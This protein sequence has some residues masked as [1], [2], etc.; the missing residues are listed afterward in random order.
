[1][2]DVPGAAE[3]TPPLYTAVSFERMWLLGGDGNLLYLPS[4]KQSTLFFKSK[5][6]Q[7]I[8]T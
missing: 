3:F 1:M 2:R 8:E 5:V 7:G 4:D 6:E